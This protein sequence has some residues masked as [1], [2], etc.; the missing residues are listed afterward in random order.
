MLVST[1]R[2]GSADR[3]RVVAS[4]PLSH[5][6]AGTRALV[7]RSRLLLAV[8]RAGRCGLRRAREYMCGSCAAVD[9]NMINISYNLNSRQLPDATQALPQPH[10]HQQQAAHTRHPRPRN[11][12][13]FLSS[14]GR[15]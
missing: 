1:L 5:S 12:K 13:I 15:R 6:R 9:R 11:I 4:F 10:H 7:T 2:S 3:A 14:C 8:L